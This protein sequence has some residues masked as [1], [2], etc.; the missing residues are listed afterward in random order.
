MKGCDY[1]ASKYP[2]CSA[3][4][5]WNLN[6]MNTLCDRPDVNVEKVTRRVNGGVNGLKD[7]IE[8][9]KKACEVI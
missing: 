1:V 7:R 9:Y 2:F 5:W 3:G 4:Y 6:D 8:Y